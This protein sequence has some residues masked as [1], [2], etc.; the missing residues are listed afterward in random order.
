[1]CFSSITKKQIVALTGLL[2]V[3]YVVLHLAG[4][5]LI[6]GGPMVFNGY[7]KKM[8]GF[9]PMLRMAEYG[10]LAAFLVHIW[11]TVL[12]VWENIQARGGLGRYAV[13]KPV[14][15]RSLATR[16]MPWT[17]TYLLI[18]VLW[19]IFDFQ[20]SNHGGPRSLINGQ[21]YGLYGVVVN[22]FADPVHS[23]LYIAAMCFLGLH[24][25]HGVESCLQ[26]FGMKNP[27]YAPAVNRFSR[28]FAVVMVL[29]YISIPLY[30]MF[31]LK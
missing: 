10:L 25:A 1:M 15:N 18:F 20:F 12:V 4:N 13:D 27:G 9:G 2:L 17:G 31:V 21:S 22:S 30:V 29:G 26:T 19:H 24:L 6:Y 28:Y 16:L 3:L 7:A 14:G 5:L 23:L 8:A 11:F